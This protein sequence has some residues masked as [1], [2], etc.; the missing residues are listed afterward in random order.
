MGCLLSAGPSVGAGR[1]TRRDRLQRAYLKTA[2]QLTRIQQ[3]LEKEEAAMQS[4]SLD[5]VKYQGAEDP[6]GR[7]MFE[8]ARPG[9]L[10]DGEGDEELSEGSGEC[11]QSSLGEFL[12]LVISEADKG[13]ELP[14][15]SQV[16]RSF[17]AFCYVRKVPF[18]ERWT[19][20]AVAKDLGCSCTLFHRLVHRWEE[21]I[22]NRRVD[23]RAA[24]ANSFSG[25][26]GEAA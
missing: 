7:T 5:S 25:S 19:L 23:T 26:G 12:R 9:A 2:A 1:L 13:R 10:I 22:E 11:Q 8:A 14:T 4:R 15:P 21:F 17:V 16:A 20:G 24:G 3:Q 6:K 18:V